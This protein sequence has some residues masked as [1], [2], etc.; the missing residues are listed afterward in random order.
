MSNIAT[1]F[2]WNELATITLVLCAVI[3]AVALGLFL[4]FGKQREQL[5]DG[6]E[7]FKAFQRY[8]LAVVGSFFKGTQKEVGAQEYLATL[9]ALS[10]AGVLTLEYDDEGEPVALRKEGGNGKAICNPV[11]EGALALLNFFVED[12]GKVH[13]NSAKER[14]VANKKL[15]DPAYRAWRQLVKSEALASQG[16]SKTALAVRQGLLYAGYVAILLAAVL[17]YLVS[18]MASTLLLATG[19]YLII[20]SFVMLRRIDA[21]RQNA[22]R[23]YLWLDGI[24]AYASE[25]PTDQHFIRVLLEYACLFALADK[26]SVALSGAV[27]SMVIEEETA[28]F[29]FWKNLRAALYTTD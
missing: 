6:L 27:D 15:I 24:E 19:I 7:L 12:D 3:A 13:L 26:L 23:F 8:P 14:G 11:D 1:G 21:E 5:S 16:V 2:I 25:L 29:V 18:L 9:M 10:H 17:G 22:R 4:V 20:L 28:S